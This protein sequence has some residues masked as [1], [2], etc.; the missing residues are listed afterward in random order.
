MANHNLALFWTTDHGDVK[1][2]ENLLGTDYRLIVSAGLPSTFWNRLAGLAESGTSL[3][4]AVLEDDPVARLHRE[5]VSIAGELATRA[6]E[7]PKVVITD[8]R[9][10]EE[11]PGAEFVDRLA[12]QAGTM[13]VR[14]TLNGLLVAESDAP[15]STFEDPS[16]GPTTEDP[17]V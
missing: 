6:V 10:Q 8:K 1:L 11:F 3:L 13:T 4:A 9:F 14:S 7:L 2:R 16:F 12:W 17:I 15:K 5:V